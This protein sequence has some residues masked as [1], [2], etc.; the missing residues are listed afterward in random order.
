M[1]VRVGGPFENGLNKYYD[2]I[3]D[4]PLTQ[5]TATCNNSKP[6]KSHCVRI[7]VAKVESR[8]TFYKAGQSLFNEGRHTDT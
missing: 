8:A 4:R 1:K 7:E 2:E 3:V 5:I 6:H